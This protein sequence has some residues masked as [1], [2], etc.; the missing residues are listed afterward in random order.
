MKR[1]STGL[2]TAGVVLGMASM[3]LAGTPKAGAPGKAA[4]SAPPS[5]AVCKMALSTKKTKTN[6]QMVKIKGKTYYCCSHCKME[7]PTKGK[8]APKKP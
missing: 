1:L 5:C 8:T 3:A 4:K 6:T 7:A 2:A